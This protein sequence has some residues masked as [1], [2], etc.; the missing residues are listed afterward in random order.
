MNNNQN[1]SGKKLTATNGVQF[2]GRGKDGSSKALSISYLENTIG[3]S[4]HSELPQN[5]QSDRSRFDYK[6][7]NA[8][9]L[10]GKSAK[11]LAGILKKAV[12]AFN[13]GEE[14]GSASV[15]SAENLIEVTTGNKFELGDSIVIVIYNGIAADKS[16]NT[17]EVFEFSMDRIITN[18]DNTTGSYN[19]DDVIA[20]DVEYFIDI[21]TEFSKYSTGA[22]AH[23]V[24]KEFSYDI[25]RFITRQLQTMQ[26]LGIQVENQYN[27]RGLN[28]N[29]YQNNGYSSRPTMTTSTSELLDEI[30]SLG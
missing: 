29:L 21:L 17:F 18:Y 23:C 10:K 12:K 22:A 7:G 11:I 24:K 6:T 16:C 1:N 14:I 19:T 3:I 4:I 26:A 8:I 13:N 2:F 28:N 20:V 25:G 27:S 9:Y 30:N 15:N 5:Q